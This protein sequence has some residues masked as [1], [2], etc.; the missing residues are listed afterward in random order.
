MVF[1]KIMVTI[2]ILALV[3]FTVFIIR[4]VRDSKSGIKFPPRVSQCPDYYEQ[5]NGDGCLNKLKLGNFTTPKCQ[6][7]DPTKNATITE[8]CDYRNECNVGWD[9]LNDE[10]CNRKHHKN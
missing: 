9:R 10:V 8:M 4:S 7:W 2:L 6:S 5:T 3:L 1:R